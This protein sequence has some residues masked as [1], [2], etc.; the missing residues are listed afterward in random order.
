MTCFYIPPHMMEKVARQRPR[1][2]GTVH[3]DAGFRA[4]RQAAIYDK[5][6]G[7][8]TIYD[9]RLKTR[10]PGVPDRGRTDQA[11]RV[12]AYVDTA[13]DV[14]E[15]DDFPDVVVRYGQGYANAF[16]NGKYL[17]FG[18]GDGEVF[19]DFTHA[20][21]VFAHEWGHHL[22]EQGPGMAYQSQPG[23]LNEHLADVVGICT[24][25]Y[26][27]QAM[28]DWRLGQEVFLDGV[29]A[30]RDMLH[31]GT[32]YASDLLGDDPQPG[33]LRDYVHTVDDNGGVHINSGIPNRAFATFVSQS[34]LKSF[35]QPFQIW[36]AAMAMA[37]RYTD[38]TSFAKM[39]V[40]CSGQFRRQ[41]IDGWA[42][43]GITAW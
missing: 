35:E 38:F 12:Q 32:A 23:A 30:V 13:R 7:D 34:G 27:Q 9:A 17:V 6:P 19:G 41:V 43:V 14:L 36:G 21:D 25:Q 10:L 20:L 31:P 5:A 24:A 33:H 42:A 16:F 15:V 28:D 1:L 4:V 22:V 8:V 11:G 29:S 39:T 37:S 2:G 26:R 40:V 3:D 18:T